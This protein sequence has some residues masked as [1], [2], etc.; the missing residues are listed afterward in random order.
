MACSEAV[1]RRGQGGV[2]MSVPFGSVPLQR[3]REYE[4]YLQPVSVRGE[5]ARERLRQMDEALGGHVGTKW[6][7]EIRQ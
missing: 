7:P 6:T 5:F 4:T 1:K 3:F 2:T